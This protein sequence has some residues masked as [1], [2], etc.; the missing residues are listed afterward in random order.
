MK[1]D[2]V[3]PFWFDVHI[4]NELVNAK[5]NNIRHTLL[6]LSAHFVWP[7]FAVMSVAIG[8]S[9]LSCLLIVLSY[10]VFSIDLWHPID[11]FA[12]FCFLYYPIRC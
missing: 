12:V 4:V 3:D 8:L 6:L 2:S 11:L 5:K 7:Y 1:T 9:V 10:F